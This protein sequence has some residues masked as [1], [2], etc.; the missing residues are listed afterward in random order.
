M[1]FFFLPFRMNYETQRFPVVTFTLIGINTM[2]WLITLIFAIATGGDSDDWVMQNLWLVTGQLHWWMW[3]THMFVHAG[4]FHLGGNMIYLF[5]FGCC[6]EDIVG[7]LRFIIMYLVGGLIAAFTYIACSPEHF[8][9]MAPMGGASGAISVCL[10][11]YLLLRADSE[12]EFKYFFVFFMFFIFFRAGEFEMPAWIAIPF[13]FLKDLVGMISGMYSASNHGGVAFGAHVGGLLAGCAMAGIYKWTTRSQKKEEE[14]AASPFES[15]RRQIVPALAA[16]Q[17]T[18]E[19][20]TI[21][22]AHDGQ[23]TGPY[24]GSQI[25]DMLRMGSISDDAHYWTEGMADWQSINEF[26]G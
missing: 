9:S 14:G 15:L 7:R 12:I 11:M 20:P 17:Q 5:L 18:E 22:L 3:L 8:A 6:V 23:Q 16:A 13:W 26:M 1:F 21:Y 25:Q 4:I 2:V 10:G 24:T 19:A